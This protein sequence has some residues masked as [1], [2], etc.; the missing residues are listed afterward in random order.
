MMGLR[1]PV[2]ES[3]ALR[4]EINRLFDDESMDTSIAWAPAVDVIESGTEILLQAELPGMKK[5][6]IEVLL[7]GD[8]LL[9]RGERQKARLDAG[10]SYQRIE[11]RFG[12]WQRSFKV[13]AQLEE[14]SITAS[15]LDG[16]LEIRLPKKAEPIPRKVSIVIG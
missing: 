16:V 8:T 4:R 7:Q 14:P 5:E 13:E 12:S 9:L 6:E 11:R 15:Y 2:S 3:R 10:E 1:L